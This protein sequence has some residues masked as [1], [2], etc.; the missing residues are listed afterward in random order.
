[1][2]VLFDGPLNNLSLGNVSFNF[3]RE[4]IKKRAVSAVFPVQDRADLSAFDCSEE[5]K[6]EI[7]SLINNRLIKI[8]KDT[9]TLRVWHINGSERRLTNKQFLYTFYE[10]DQ[11][12]VEE[13]TIVAS[14]E[15]TFFSSTESCE[16]FKK[17][18]LENVSYVPI[19]FDPDF[20]R[21]NKKYLP[22]GV[23]NFGLVGKFEYRKNTKKIIQAW[24]KKFGNDSRFQLT[25]LIHNPFF[26][27]QIMNQILAQTLEGKSY[28]NINLI[29]H[30]EKNSM[31]NEVYNAI[32]ID[33]SGM[34][35]NEGWGLPSFNA[36]CLGKICV[37]GNGGA[38]KD[39]AYGKNIILMEPD[40]KR[41]AY[42]NFFF[43][44]G[45]PFNQGTF[46]DFNED[47]LIDGMERALKLKSSYVEE[48]RLDLQEEFSYK[49][50]IDK[51]LKTIFNE[52]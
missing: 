32:D 23:V 40:G 6:P 8:N 1:M 11:P 35:G 4:L 3:L 50:S 34:N 15:H 42:D 9:P 27:P 24:L 10:C 31:V 49:K 33:L 19:G 18:G 39:W 43:K 2:Q 7:V 51:I 16:S 12:T 22:E 21:T 44:E 46:Y 52:C 45:L 37:V 30:Q 36:A 20:H 28:S 38:H 5:M 29:P 25:C 17:R 14:Q 48:E 47:T 41:P 26:E 13:M